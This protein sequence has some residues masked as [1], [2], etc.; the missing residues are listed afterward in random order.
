ML[1]L[2]VRTKIPRRGTYVRTFLEEW[3]RSGRLSFTDAAKMY[4][5]RP[6]GRSPSMRHVGLTLTRY[7]RRFGQRFRDARGRSVGWEVRPAVKYALDTGSAVV[8]EDVDV[9]AVP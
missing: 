2:Q 8:V 1:S 9:G 5:R 7:L 4:A 3:A 6:A